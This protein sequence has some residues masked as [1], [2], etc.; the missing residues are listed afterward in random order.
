MGQIVNGT[1]KGERTY[2]LNMQ[3]RYDGSDREWHGEW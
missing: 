3:S 1:T 2:T